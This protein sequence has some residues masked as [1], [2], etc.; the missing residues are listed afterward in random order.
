[1]RIA[2]SEGNRHVFNLELGEELFGTLLGWCE[3]EGVAG[4]TLTGLGAA[5]KLDVA[6]YDLAAKAYERH[7]LEEE[8][9]VLSLVGNLGMLDGKRLLHIHGIFGRKNLSTFGGHL[10]ELRVSGACEIH[11]TAL[12]SP[13][14][15]AYDA[16][17]GLNLLCAA[18]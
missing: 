13:L 11:L 18:A 6:Y 9:E 12:A 10:F 14:E 16:A 1:M 15:R 4:A 2:A 3:R 17:T 8:V 7:P 5:D